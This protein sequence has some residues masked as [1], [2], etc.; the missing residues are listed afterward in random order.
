MKSFI[1]ELLYII[2]KY[3]VGIFILIP[4]ISLLVLYLIPWYSC[5]PVFKTLKKS[6]HPG[7]RVH[8]KFNRTA[9]INLYARST[10]ELVRIDEDGAFHEE[11]KITWRINIGKGTKQI[12]VSYKLLDNCVNAIRKNMS[13]PCIHYEENTY[14]WIGNTIYKPFGLIER[15]FYWE[16]TPF[17]IYEN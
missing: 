15:S 6:Y 16:S 7:E 17:K 13:F 12:I 14:H 11:A 2:K 4:I 9:L 3:I 8:V 1:K 10:R 5:D